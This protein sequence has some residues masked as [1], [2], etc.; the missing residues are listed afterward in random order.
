[1]RLL[2]P[3]AVRL[4]RGNVI[5]PDLVRSTQSA[6]LSDIVLLHEKSVLLHVHLGNNTNAYMITT[7]VVFRQLLLYLIC[8]GVLQ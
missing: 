6:G 7:G 1:M 3:T 4:N 8:P 2:F 5:L